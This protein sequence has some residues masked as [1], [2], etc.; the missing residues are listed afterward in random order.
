M[1]PIG[2]GEKHPPGPIDADAS[3]ARVLL[4]QLGHFPIDHQARTAREGLGDALWPV[5]ARMEDGGLAVA[6]DEDPPVGASEW[7]Q[8]LAIGDAQPQR[9]QL[10]VKKAPV[11]CGGGA[12]LSG[13]FPDAGRLLFGLPP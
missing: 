9:P 3:P 11:D 7:A 12:T 13:Q 2:D 8:L 6:D 5:V 1:V 4:L 10:L